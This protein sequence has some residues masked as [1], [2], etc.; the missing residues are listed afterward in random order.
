MHK[1]KEWCLGNWYTEYEAAIQKDKKKQ[2]QYFRFC[3][4][5]NWCFS[6]F[7]LYQ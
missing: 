2:E 3:G 6:Q 7:S 5:Q 1:P 4:L